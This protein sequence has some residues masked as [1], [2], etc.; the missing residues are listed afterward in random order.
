VSSERSSRSVREKPIRLFVAIDVPDEVRARLAAALAPFRDA[1]PGARWTR[2]AGW[3]V[4]VKFLGWVRPRLVP[5]VEAAVR[6]AAVRSGAFETAITAIG[7]F[8]SP[9]R[10]RVLWAGLDDGTGCFAQ[11]V[12]QLD[13]LLSA[14]FEPET[15]AFTPHLT[16]ARIDPPRRLSEFAPDLVSLDVASERF[17][18]ER[19][20][21]YRS[22]LSPQGATYEAVFDAALGGSP[23][24]A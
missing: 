5:E 8:P 19:L 23:R 11:M 6:S 3:H 18:I 21:L 15:R 12:G 20:V 16:L 7:A 22:R 10:A 14:S 2:D 17:R 13:D 1:I 9:G 4:T 24:G